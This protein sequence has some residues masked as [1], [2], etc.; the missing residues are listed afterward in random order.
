[1]SEQPREFD[2][3]LGGNNPPP[4]TG[5]VLGGIEGVKL[6]LSNP[7][8]EVKLAALS[9]ALKYGDKGLELVIQALQQDK[10]IIQRH[11]YKLLRC[12]QEKQV[13]QALLEYQPWNLFERLQGYRGYKD[14]YVECFANRQVVDYNREIGIENPVNT[15]YALRSN[16]ETSSI[17]EQL[18]H[19]LQDSQASN[20]EALVIGRWDVYHSDSSKIVNALVNSKNKL[21]NLKAIFLG[22]VVSGSCE[23]SWIRQSDISPILRAYPQLE[24]LQ[25]RGGQGLKFNA[26]LIHNNLQALILE[27]AGLSRETV[28]QICRMKLPELEHLELWF[29][30]QDNGGDFS[31]VDGKPILEDLIFPYL[32]YLGLRNS[33]FTDDIAE[34]V[35]KSPL[36]E[37]ISVLD[38]SL[39]NLTDAGGEYLLNCPAVNELDILN[40]SEARLSE[41]MISKLSSLNCQLLAEE[42][43]T[44]PDYDDEYRYCAVCE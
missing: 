8:V 19:L 15:A 13:K 7:V 21:T 43:D 24:L 9:D 6:R 27:T 42:Q 40:V 44:D 33:E 4:V 12:R 10:K 18:T 37:T 16:Y 29:G 2:A 23:I 35:V 5:V 20:L 31:V 39:G 32:N 30:S 28:G 38:L 41:E 34:V 17:T 11:A 25:I 26:P 36:I 1:M 22:D 14:L 3:V